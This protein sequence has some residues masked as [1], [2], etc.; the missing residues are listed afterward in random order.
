MNQFAIDLFVSLLQKPE[1]KKYSTSLVLQYPVLFSP[2]FW[3]QIYPYIKEN[4]PA[5]TADAENFL[6]FLETGY[7]EFASGNGYP[8]GYGPLEHIYEQYKEGSIDE[9]T[10]LTL[11]KTQTV[12]QLLSPVYISCLCISAEKAVNKNRSL[13]KNATVLMNI[14]IGAINAIPETAKMKDEWEF[15]RNETAAFYLN[16]GIYALVEVPDKR[17]LDKCVQYGENIA[18]ICL[19]ENNSRFAGKIYHQLG[20][21]HLDPYFFE[22]NSSNYKVQFNKWQQQVYNYYGQ[23][24]AGVDAETILMPSAA[25]AMKKAIAYFDKALSFRQAISRGLTLKALCEALM[26]QNFLAGTE[27]YERICKAGPEAIDLLSKEEGN[28]S[29]II[30]LLNVLKR[31]NCTA[32]AQNIKDFNID[33]ILDSTPEVLME[34]YGSSALLSKIVNQLDY[35]IT[36]DKN[37]ALNLYIKAQDILNAFPDEAASNNFFTK[38]IELFFALS[39]KIVKDDYKQNTTELYNKFIARFKQNI[40]YDFNF[41]S[42]LITIA[43]QSTSKNEEAS[44]LQILKIISTSLAENETFSFLIPLINYLTAILQIGEAVN[45]YN[46]NNFTESVTFYFLA[47]GSFNQLNY[48]KQQNDSLDEI[49]DLCSKCDEKGCENILAKLSIIFL[50]LLK[51]GSPS[52]SLKCNEIYR[53]LL[54]RFCINQPVKPIILIMLFQLLKGYSFASLLTLRVNFSLKNEDEKLLLSEIEN[55]F[56]RQQI[57]FPGAG[58]KVLDKETI[59]IA[60]AGD[61]SKQSGNDE[62]TRLKNLRISFDDLFYSNMLKQ[63]DTKDCMIMPDDLRTLLDD[64]SVL[65]IHY[66]GSSVEGMAASYSM[67]VTKVGYCF[68]YGYSKDIPSGYVELT[69]D[70]VKVKIP[71]LAFTISGVRKA[72]INDDPDETGLSRDASTQLESFRSILLGGE[73]PSYLEEF[74]KQGKNKLYIWPHS[75]F[76]YFPFHLLQLPSGKLLCEEWMVADIP[77]LAALKPKQNPLS[78]EHNVSVMAMT[79][80]KNNPYKVSE[81]S[82]AISLTKPV[83]DLFSVE[84]TSDEANTEAAFLKNLKSSKWVHLYTHGY[85]TA[86]APAFH[87]LF[88][89]PGQNEDGILYAYEIAGIDLSNVDL[90]TLCACETALGRFDNNDN[91][92]GLPASFL[93][94]GVSTIIGTLWESEPESSAFFFKYLYQNLKQGLTKQQSFKAAQS[95]TRASYPEF[96]DWGSFYYL[97]Q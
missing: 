32:I 7:K 70:S 82:D 14:A 24:L 3:Q 90:L 78:A 34:K 5:T 47:L 37:K 27:T 33:E 69:E 45:Q 39:D 97:G 68:T 13:W 81:L 95:L 28:E 72:I 46:Q 83:A 58:N 55:L 20:V 41:Y 85:L 91:L 1:Q 79:F 66:L 4:F 8:Y 62:L 23:A 2:A 15:M 6:S 75:S 71:M 84:V 96:R 21:L 87:A 29:K 77:N 61:N 89:E 40:A 54:Q 53:M 52:I 31:C 30:W 56:S 19:T 43:A 10:A 25:D 94:A 12:S 44:G 88:L 76:H 9:A 67:F 64:A 38:A 22:K 17:L 92:R 73:I 51:T 26:W 50:R 18:N 35:C 49:A 57:K 36:V 59:L 80:T 93:L 60:Y 42:S 48:I 65:M 86:E 74:K 63:V 16:I 11:A